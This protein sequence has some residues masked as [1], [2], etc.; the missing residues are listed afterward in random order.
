[1]NDQPNS[2]LPSRRALRAATAGTENGAPGA[3]KDSRRAVKDGPPR[4]SRPRPLRRRSQLLV[5]VVVAL[6]AVLVGVLV[7]VMQAYL[8]KP[9][10]QNGAPPSLAGVEVTGRLGALPTL[11]LPTEL[12]LSLPGQV[13][14]VE[15]GFGKVVR[16]DARVVLAITTFDGSTGRQTMAGQRPRI[17][18]VEATTQNL[19]PTIFSAVAGRPEGTR[20]L[21]MT[22][23]EEEGRAYQELAVVDILPSLLA[24]APSQPGASSPSEAADAAPSSAPTAAPDGQAPTLSSMVTFTLEGTPVLKPTGKAAPIVKVEELIPGTGEQVTLGDTVVLQFA[25]MG[26]DGTLHKSSY[27]EAG[28]QKVKLDTLQPGLAEALT[29]REVG[30]RL[31]FSVPAELA[32]G[33]GDVLA[34][35]DLLAIAEQAEPAQE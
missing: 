14:V 1:M 22:P 7:G 10:T 33:S 4:A 3:G 15:S 35:V 9:A 20:L 13:R 18:V 27:A 26:W 12:P 32:D 24:S 23:V 11:S 29:D 21:L 31:V 25:L 19:G 34:M 2:P 28:P 8:S 5:W 17:E 30:S 6:L 16:E